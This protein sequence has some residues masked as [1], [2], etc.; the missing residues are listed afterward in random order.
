[1]FQ[2]PK[3]QIIIVLGVLPGIINRASCFLID[4]RGLTGLC[5][6]L[7]QPRSIRGDASPSE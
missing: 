2:I 4:P 1:M 7:F 6:S 3:I 5:Y